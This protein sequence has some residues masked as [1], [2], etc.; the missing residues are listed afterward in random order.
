MKTE[1]L[2]LN[3]K[4]DSSQKHDPISILMLKKHSSL[5]GKKCFFNIRTEVVSRIWDGSGNHAKNPL[6]HFSQ[7]NLSLANDSASIVA[8]D[9]LFWTISL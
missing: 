8:F 2:K 4:A 6:F 3:S 1:P 9:P 5:L 7:F